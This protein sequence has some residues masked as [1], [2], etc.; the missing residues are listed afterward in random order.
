MT[1][2]MPLN[3]LGFVGK[4][5]EAYGK[6]K[7]AGDAVVIVRGRPRWFIMRCPCGCD[8]NLTVNLDAQAGPAWR[9][10]TNDKSGITLYPSVWR[11]TGC[12]SHFIIWRSKVF[13][14]G[15]YDSDEWLSADEDSKLYD[16]VRRALKE[17]PTD[18]SDIA[19]D[20]DAIPWDVLICCR[21]LVRS[22]V[23]VE[24]SGKLRGK[25]SLRVT[26]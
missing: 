18:Y 24:G 1:S 2:V 9:L 26:R 3:F 10:Y 7:R 23:A 20:L 11:D 21:R 6:L 5:S 17:V 12:G 22:G 19:Y 14:L 4:H 16:A 13:L 15:A 8:E 25:F